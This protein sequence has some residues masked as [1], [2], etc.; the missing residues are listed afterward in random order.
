VDS[1]PAA[2]SLT[3][4]SD[5]APTKSTGSITGCLDRENGTLQKAQNLLE[6]FVWLID[7]G[8]LMG[9]TDFRVSLEI[10]Y[11]ADYKVVDTYVK[12][13]PIVCYSDNH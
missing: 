4:L 13:P 7:T 5:L 10:V 6:D 1:L 12:R 2:H 8:R 3:T 9:D 11:S